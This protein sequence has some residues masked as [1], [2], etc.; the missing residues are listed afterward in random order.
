VSDLITGNNGTNGARTEPVRGSRLDHGRRTHLFSEGF[1]S[2]HCEGCET[3]LRN[4]VASRAETRKNYRQP[5]LICSGGQR[6]S[7]DF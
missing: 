5:T 2:F 7:D 4:V 1:M 3:S 6:G